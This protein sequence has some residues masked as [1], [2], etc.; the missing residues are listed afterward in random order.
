MLCYANSFF[1]TFYSDSVYAWSALWS[2][3]Q[4]KSWISFARQCWYIHL[5][6]CIY[7]YVICLE[8]IIIPGLLAFYSWAGTNASWS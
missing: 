6:M 4:G 3:E 2:P 7:A 1:P 8:H 5:H